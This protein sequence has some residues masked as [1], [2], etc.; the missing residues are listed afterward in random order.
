ML[1]LILEGWITGAGGE[2]TWERKSFLGEKCSQLNPGS[3][4]QWGKLNLHWRESI[5]PQSLWCGKIF[6]E[7]NWETLNDYSQG[8]G[9]EGFYLREIPL[10]AVCMF[11]GRRRTR[12]WDS[13]R[14]YCTSG[15]DV[16]DER[17]YTSN[18]GRGCQTQE[19]RSP[20]LT[21]CRMS[22]RWK[23]RGDFWPGK[24]T[25]ISQYVNWDR[26]Y[27]RSR[28][29]VEARKEVINPVLHVQVDTRGWQL[30]IRLLMPQGKFELEV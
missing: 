24:D 16:G 17:I 13:N 6:T 26:K 3:R 9:K 29:F 11:M 7:G 25:A 18:G 4:R 22:Q 23:P 19:I 21:S 1:K 10:V 27:R 12:G 14:S 5:K 30:N 2:D 8:N 20:R 15:W 28:A